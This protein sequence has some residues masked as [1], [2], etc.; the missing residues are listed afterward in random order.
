MGSIRERTSGGA[1]R[2]YFQFQSK[3]DSMNELLILA[4]AF[5]LAFLIETLV[6]YLVG[7]P[8]NHIPKLLP[9]KWLLMYVSAGVGVGLSLFYKLDLISLIFQ[10]AATV[11]GIVITG[12][13]IGRGSNYLH[14]FVS[15]FFPGKPV[16]IA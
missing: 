2:S 6:V 10:Q 11:V 14:Q 13:A 16:P 1:Y 8:I 12:L 7:E 3:G 4:G 9:F 15:K 5:A